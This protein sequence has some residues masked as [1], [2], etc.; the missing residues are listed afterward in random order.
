[1]LVYIITGNE[2]DYQC[3]HLSCVLGPLVPVSKMSSIHAN[4]KVEDASLNKGATSK[5]WHEKPWNQ[6]TN[7]SVRD[8]HFLNNCKLTATKHYI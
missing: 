7:K 2:G 6:R 4:R 1:V 8:H 3:G 5:W